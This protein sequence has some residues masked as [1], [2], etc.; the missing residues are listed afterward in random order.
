MIA[1]HLVGHEWEFAVYATLLLL[2]GLLRQTEPARLLLFIRSFSNINLVEQ[3]IRQERSF[4]RFAVFVFALTL[5]GVSSFI[6]VSMRFL[7]H[8]SEFSFI[9]LWS[10]V[11]VF[12]ILLTTGRVAVYAF[13]AWLL[14]VDDL[15]QKHTFYWLLN[16]FLLAALLIVLSVL[17]SFGPPNIGATMIVIGWIGLS[18]AY[19]LRNIRL[20]IMAATIHHLPMIYIFLYLCALEILPI[21]LLLATILSQ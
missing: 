14:D 11:L 8:F 19:L 13:I 16:N 17:Y 21:W 9:G 10:L 18:A 2:F 6:T 1:Q 4:S 5:M 20:V 12:N 7:G 3:Q 15:Q